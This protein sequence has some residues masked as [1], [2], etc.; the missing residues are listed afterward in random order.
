MS[1]LSVVGRAKISILSRRWKGFCASCPVFDFHPNNFLRKGG[2]DLNYN[3]FDYLIEFKGIHK[4]IKKF[5]KFID[6]SSDQFCEAKLCIQE[7]RLLVG[8]LDVEKSFRRVDRWIGL[9]L[10][11]GVKE[12]DL[13]VITDGSKVYSF[14]KAIFSA[15]SATTLKPSGC[16]LEQ[17][18]NI[19]RFNSLKHLTLVRVYINEQLV[20]RLTSECPLREDLLLSLCTGLKRL[21]VSKADKLK[22]IKVKT[23]Q[24]LYWKVLKLM[25]QVFK[26]KFFLSLGQ[27][28]D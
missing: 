23:F 18:S 2:F 17:P 15:K 7:F 6:A 5:M 28:L 10:E 3:N 12:L 14:P 13:E 1:F 11:N 9:V 19:I 26:S 4:R 22:I 25:F 8:V 21:C 27:L 16:K 24:N 20:Q